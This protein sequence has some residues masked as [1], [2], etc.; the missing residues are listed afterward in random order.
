MS[1]LQPCYLLFALM[2]YT[3]WMWSLVKNGGR[4]LFAEVRSWIFDQTWLCK[5]SLSFVR[6]SL[7]RINGRK[8]WPRKTI[9]TPAAQ[10]VY[11]YHDAAY[12]DFRI[13]DWP[14]RLKHKPAIF[15]F[16]VTT[17]RML[18]LPTQLNNSLFRWLHKSFISFS[19]TLIV[20]IGV[21]HP[22]HTRKQT[23]NGW[24]IILEAVVISGSVRIL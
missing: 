1:T 16:L 19:S 3:M 17:T 14:A 8:I 22:I 9:R 10:S 15:Q 12:M 5:Q 23:E 11:F 18:L 20:E 7:S 24:K 21:F 13:Q 4:N 6:L 2:I